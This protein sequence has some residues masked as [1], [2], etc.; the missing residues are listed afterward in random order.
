[1]D[2]LK[3]HMIIKIVEDEDLLIA[4]KDKQMQVIRS[5]GW[6]LQKADNPP[7]LLEE[8]KLYQIKANYKYKILK[9]DGNLVVSIK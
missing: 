2:E 7:I 6:S 4:D 9:G 8:E 1:M 3:K 5:S